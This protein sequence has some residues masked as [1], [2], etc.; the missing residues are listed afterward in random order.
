MQKQ[1]LT[2]IKYRLDDPVIQ[3]LLPLFVQAKVQ[4][5]LAEQ[6]DEEAAVDNKHILYADLF[7]CIDAEYRDVS[8]H[9]LLWIGNHAT[10]LYNIYAGGSSCWIKPDNHY[11]SFSAIN[12]ALLPILAERDPSTWWIVRESDSDPLGNLRVYR[13]HIVSEDQVSNEFPDL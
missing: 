8:R 6:D 9:I 13:I 5:I 1:L 3:R 2:H 11:L 4:E 7:G 10:T 12:E